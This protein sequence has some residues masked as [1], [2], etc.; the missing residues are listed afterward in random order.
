MGSE[1]V[2]AGAGAAAGAAAAG[3]TG[4][5]EGQWIPKDR[6]DEVN[7]K[8]KETAAKLS[9]A[10]LK[11]AELQSGAEAAVGWQTKATKAE[12]ER[13]SIKRQHL[14]FLDGVKVGLTSPTVLEHA[15]REWEALPAEGRKGFG[16]VLTGWKDRPEEAPELLRPHVAA[17]GKAAP[18]AAGPPKPPQAN[19]GAGAPPAPGARVKVADLP[20]EQRKQMASWFF[21]R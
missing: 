10:E 9:A 5:P 7:N 19:R 13:D 18:G 6:F 15:Y 17:I 2:G 21:G 20:E 11:L 4:K 14:A 12:A 1:D 8:A 16:E 3:A